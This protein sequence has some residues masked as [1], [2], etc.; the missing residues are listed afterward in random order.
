VRG[1]AR[2]IITR[3]Q[4]LKKKAHLNTEDAI[5]I[6]YKFGANAKY[7]NAAVEN[8][9]KAIANAVKKPFLHSDQHFGLIDIAHDEGTVEEEQ[10]HLK[11]SA[12]GPIFNFA[13]LTVTLL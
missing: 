13:E 3:V 12:P 8:E 6:F 9:R 7:L 5:I 4:K 10:Y 11:I 2:E 1:F